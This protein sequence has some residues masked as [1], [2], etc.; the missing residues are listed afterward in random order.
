M[1]LGAL[2][3]FAV[4]QA[5]VSSQRW[6][7]DSNRGTIDRGVMVR[8]SGLKLRHS[9]CRRDLVEFTIAPILR[10]MGGRARTY[11]QAM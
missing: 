10:A 4:E 6:K 7:Q 11:G 5:L 1:R 2:V 9:R 3:G 8:R